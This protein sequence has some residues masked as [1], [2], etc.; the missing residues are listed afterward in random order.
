MKEG[1]GAGW[2]GG[3]GAEVGK[4]GGGVTFGGGARKGGQQGRGHA[5]H[6]CGGK[7]CAWG[8]TLPAR[9][10]LNQKLHLLVRRLLLL[11]AAAGD[12]KALTAS[13]TL[14]HGLGLAHNGG[15]KGGQQGR[16][17]FFSLTASW[18]S[19]SHAVRLVSRRP[20]LETTLEV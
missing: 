18:S 3:A 5:S 8:Q 15:G 13:L 16:V 10:A 6:E 19:L 12:S 17:H 20:S 1:G 2:G 11:S 14:C 9:A 4:K 7:R